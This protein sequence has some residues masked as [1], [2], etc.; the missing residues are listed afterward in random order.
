LYQQK[1]LKQLILQMEVT[2]YIAISSHAT[3]QT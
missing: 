1:Q 3:V 2:M